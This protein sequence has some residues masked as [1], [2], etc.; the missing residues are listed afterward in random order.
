MTLFLS[1]H[2]WAQAGRG[3]WKIP[4]RINLVCLIGSFLPRSTKESGLANK[5]EEE[6]RQIV[7]ATRKQAKLEAAEKTGKA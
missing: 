7:K 1:L 3:E 6:N 5:Y 2:R 4:I